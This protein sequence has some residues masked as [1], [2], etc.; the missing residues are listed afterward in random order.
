AHD[1][2][3]AEVGF[4]LPADALAGAPE[5]REAARRVSLAA[6]FHRHPSYGTPY[7]C[8][9][10]P[11]T[12]P[13]AVRRKRGGAMAVVE[14]RGPRKTYPGKTAPGGLG[15]G[16]AQGTGRGPRGPHG[17]GQADA[18]GLPTTPGRK[19]GA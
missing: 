9:A 4:A 6:V 10:P 11:C 7:G 8:A 16:V 12:V 18:G 2:V 19:G 13:Y 14:A 15:P 1:P 5:Q 3:D 17:A